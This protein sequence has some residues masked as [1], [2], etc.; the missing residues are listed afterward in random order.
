M[1]KYNVSKKRGKS[2]NKISEKREAAMRKIVDSYSEE[3]DVKMSVIQ[4]LIPL[5]LKA[6][7]EELKNEVIRLAGEKHSRGGN[8][9]RWGGQNGSVYLRDQKFPIK[10]PRVRD[11]AANREVALE[12]YQRL[13]EPFDDEGAMRRL[14]HG[15]STH[16]YQESSSLA[17]EAFGISASNLSKKFK[18]CSGDKLQQLQTRS[19]AQHDIIVVFIDAK[20]YADD[21]IIVGLG[22]TMDGKKIVL[23]I[24]H[25]HSEN[26][27]AIEQWL[28]RLIERGLK[29]ERGILFIID[30]S[31][32][33][34]KAIEHK[35]SVYALI[36]RCRWHKRENVVAYLDEAQQAVFRRR[37]Q[38]AYAQTTYK[39]GKAALLQLHQELEKVNASAANSLQ[40]G[41]EETLTIHHLGLSPELAKSLST[42]NCVE[43]VMSLLGS[44]T[45]KVD[46]WH[47]SDQILRWTGMGLMDIEP[48]LNRIQGHRYLKILRYK[49][50][51]I[52]DQRLNKESE[53][54]ETKIEKV[55]L[56]EVTGNR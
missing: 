28:D 25:V 49:L 48:R 36:Q 17:A 24:E 7:A 4:E 11:V 35:F 56:V 53:I 20:R 23:G 6:V 21:G 55:S 15:L 46:R 5:G 29:F 22:V 8:N 43:G 13:Q 32:G 47:N 27:R 34:K 54:D 50:Q 39:E 31:K 30:G 12:V 52:I 37:L 10:V 45:D 18:Q 9:A 33:I 16:K 26:G 41:L 42:T 1:P 40:E 2:K 44:Y 19:L 3:F 14:L 38:E 51:E